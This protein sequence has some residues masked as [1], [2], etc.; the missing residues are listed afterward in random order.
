MRYQFTEA[1]LQEQR[2][3]MTALSNKWRAERLAREARERR[4]FGFCP[5]AELLNARVAMFFFAVGMITEY[6]TGQSMPQ[7][8]EYFLRIL[9]II[10]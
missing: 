8:I 7:Q 3:A 5:R 1:E 6:V 9:G 10:E 4:W 2:R